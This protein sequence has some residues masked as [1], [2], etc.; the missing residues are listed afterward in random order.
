MAYRVHSVGFLAHSAQASLSIT[1]QS[2]E[3][4]SLVR[5]RWLMVVSSHCQ[6]AT[7]E[8]VLQA[9]RVEDHFPSNDLASNG[10]ISIRNVQHS[11]TR[12]IPVAFP[13]SAA[14]KQAKPGKPQELPRIF[15]CKRARK[16]RRPR[17]SWSTLGPQ[18]SYA[19]DPQAAASGDAECS[20]L[21]I[22]TGEPADNRPVARESISGDED[23][24]TAMLW[25]PE[26]GKLELR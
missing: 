3:L 6:A 21:K 12:V 18:G 10:A 26:P 16:P 2:Y 14:G 22:T 5:D 8:A 4:L 15:T 23:H 7:V 24:R 13:S 17:D 1:L 25:S 20:S 11:S 9:R 19:E